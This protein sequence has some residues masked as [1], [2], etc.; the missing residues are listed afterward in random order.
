M[1]ET[2]IATPRNHC[3]RTTSGLPLDNAWF[4]ISCFYPTKRRSLYMLIVDVPVFLSRG[5]SFRFT[6]SQFNVQVLIG[7]VIL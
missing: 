3:E 2:F 4:Q 1:T 7:L 6:I 5:L